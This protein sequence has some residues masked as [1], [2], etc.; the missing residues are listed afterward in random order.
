MKA[1]HTRA[2]QMAD[3]IEISY[4]YTIDDLV[5]AAEALDRLNPDARKIRIAMLVAGV[6]LIVGPFVL[7][8]P[9]VPNWFAIIGAYTAFFGLQTP[10]RITRRYYKK[11]FAPESCEAH[12]SEEGIT[13][14]SS[15][16]RS[17]MKWEGF[18]L[19]VEGKHTFVAQRRSVVY[20]IPK[21]AFTNE[22]AEQ[23]RK[24]FK[25]NTKPSPVLLNN[26]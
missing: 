1:G 21:R 23:F 3:K 6:F 26:K 17:E 10:A 14:V 13:T 16:G 18:Q 24:L 22:Q 12:I 2:E 9:W 19:V 7:H 20:T 25:Q 4:E 11:N 15:T 8:D 5:D